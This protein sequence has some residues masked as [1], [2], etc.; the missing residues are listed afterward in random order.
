MFI[1]KFRSKRFP[2]VDEAVV[3]IIKMFDQLSYQG[4][5]KLRKTFWGTYIDW[6]PMPLNKKDTHV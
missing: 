3:E 5:I 4:I 1:P 2:T 6:Q